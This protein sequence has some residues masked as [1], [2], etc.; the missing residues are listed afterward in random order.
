MRK[1][2]KRAKERIFKE[3]FFYYYSALGLQQKKV[4]KVGKKI[5][6]GTDYVSSTGQSMWI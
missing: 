3:F 2:R 5:I 6:V 4:R 1:R